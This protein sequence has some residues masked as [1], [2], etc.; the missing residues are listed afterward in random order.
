[1]NNLHTAVEYLSIFTNRKMLQKL[2]EIPTADFEQ[3]IEH[4]NPSRDVREAEKVEECPPRKKIDLDLIF[5]EV[6]QVVNESLELDE[7]YISIPE[8]KISSLRDSY[9]LFDSF[10]QTISLERKIVNSITEARGTLA[11]EYGHFLLDYFL[12]PAL[13][14]SRSVLD[15][16]FASGV[17][18]TF[19]SSFPE[20]NQRKLLQEFS[21]GATLSSLMRSRELLS[22]RKPFRSYNDK[23]AAGNSLFSA[24]E[25]WRGKEIYKEILRREFKW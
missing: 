13:G 5:A 15:E 12:W 2:R 14:E 9:G 8:L 7:K 4:Y 17:E 16:G 21:R 10:T 11:H 19:A 24:L 22:K 20:E 23:A 1:M 25:E 3:V 6:R 18:R